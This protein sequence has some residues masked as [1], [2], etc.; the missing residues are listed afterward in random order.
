MAPVTDTHWAGDDRARRRYE[1]MK[2]KAAGEYGQEA[3][4]LRER[5]DF[6]D[7]YDYFLRLA[8]EPF[9][10]AALSQRVGAPLAGLFCLQ[11]PLEIFLA[12]GLHPVRL[13][14]GSQ[15]AQQAAAS[16]LPVLMCPMLKSF[17]GHTLLYENDF[18][19][20]QTVVLPTTCDWVVKIPE[21][22]GEDLSALHYMELPHY[23]DTEKARIAWREEVFSLVAALEEKTGKK[24]TASSLRAAVETLTEVWGIFGALL[25][26]RRKGVLPGIWVLLLANTFL[27]DRLPVW[28]DHL[29]RVLQTL[30]DRPA[31][32][33]PAGIFMAGSPIVFPNFKMLE[34]IEQAGMAAIADDLCTSERI[35]PG[36]V[37]YRDTSRDGLLRSLAERYHTGCICPTF[38]DND[39]R[40]NNIFL[41]AETAPIR[42]VVYH[43]LKGC[44]PY[45]I[46]A[47][48]V[49][50]RL[51]ESGLKFIK[52][53]TD[54][55]REDSQ[56]IAT[57]LEAFRQTLE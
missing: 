26:L 48:T 40:V 1:R 10:A 51:R 33:V 7:V 21:I 42:G 49:E 39:R 16:S 36:G 52:I 14:A 17:V 53:E 44:H 41:A 28:T 15:I 54:Y 29:R 35:F 9:S 6:L 13:C 19:S 50:R 31:A 30:Q 38:I 8:E 37:A 57:R 46:E 34:I 23:R 43:L 20:F 47:I 27:L 25:N 32:P 56:N 5:A 55:G 45:D 18:R 24:L 2:G 4:R 22:M 11:A 3:A 12:L